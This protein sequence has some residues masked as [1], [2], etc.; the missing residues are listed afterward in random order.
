[1]VCNSPGKC[2]AAPAAA[3]PGNVSQIFSALLKLSA[4]KTDHYYEDNC[5]PLD[6]IYNMHE[7][8]L[9]TCTGIFYFLILLPER[10]IYF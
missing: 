4:A 3:L 2:P 1:V 5:N 8:L 6:S 9:M 10:E 7:V